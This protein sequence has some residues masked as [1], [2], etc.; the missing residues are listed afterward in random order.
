MKD[1]LKI[2]LIQLD[3]QQDRDTNVKKALKMT[4]EA[5]EKGAKAIFLPELFHLRLKGESQFSRGES[6]PGPSTE[7]FIDLASSKEVWILA[8]S[9]LEATDAEKVYNTSVWIT[10]AGQVET[11]RKIHLFDVELEAGAIRESNRFLS[12]ISSKLVTL[13][14]Y[15]MG[16]GVCY[17]LRFPELFREYAK[18]RVELISLPSS[19]TAPTGKD[20]WEVLVRARAIENQCFMIAP[21]QV[22]IGAG[23]IRTYGNSM[24][25]DPWGRILVRGSSDQE[26]V[27]IADL[28]MTLISKVRQQIPALEHR[29]L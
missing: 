3:S 8:G 12:G 22:G 29:H 16:M 7:P 25:V 2:A 26:E 27:L 11:Y 21:N 23:G 14:P 1:N 24:V 20:H 28:D 19:F 9:V 17:D 6:I 18:D 5:I 10:P 15:K 13:G 4:S